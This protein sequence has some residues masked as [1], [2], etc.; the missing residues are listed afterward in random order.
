MMY[1][2]Q[3]QKA[4]CTCKLLLLSIEDFIQEPQ[5]KNTWAKSRQTFSLLANSSN[6]RKMQEKLMKANQ[7]I[8]NLGNQQKG[9]ITNHQA[10]EGFLKED[11]YLVSIT[12]KKELD[13]ARNVWKRE[14]NNSKRQSKESK[15]GS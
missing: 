8:V 11:K 6:R 12:N 2:S 4:T 5:I 7:M 1:H 10:F 14:E 13:Q 9:R 15:K 3:W